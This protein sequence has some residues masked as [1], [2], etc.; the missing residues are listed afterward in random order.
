ML[1]LQYLIFPYHPLTRDGQ[2]RQF[3]Q[4]RSA[5]NLDKKHSIRRS[6]QSGNQW[7]C[8]EDILTFLSESSRNSQISL[9]TNWPE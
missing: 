4:M 3:Q 7:N 9:L 6:I 2:N 8:N 1:L 5:K